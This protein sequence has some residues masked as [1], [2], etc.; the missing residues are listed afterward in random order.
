MKT[1]STVLAFGLILGLVYALPPLAV[2]EAPRGGQQ[3][4]SALV[5]NRVRFL[6]APQGEQ[7][8]VGGV[9]SGSNTSATQGFEVLAEI[10][11]LPPAGQWSELTLP[12]KKPY[13]WIRYEAPRGSYGRVSK[14]EFCAGNT[15]LAGPLI[16]PFMSSKWSPVVTD[17]PSPGVSGVSPDGQYVGIDLGEKASCPRP[18]IRPGGGEFSQA[19]T[20]TMQC[21]MPGAMIRYTTDGTPPTRENG[22]TYSTSISIDKTTTFRAVGFCDGLAPSP[23]ADAVLLLPPIGRRT[24]LHLGN[25]LTG[26]AVGR[27]ALHART[28][29]V[30]HDTKAFLMGGGIARTLWNTAMIGSGDTADQ[31]RWKDLFTTTNSMGGVGTYP[32]A[33]VEQAAADWKKLWPS[34]SHVSDVTFQPRDADVAEEADY[35]I[36][37]L[38]LVRDKFP[39]VQPWLYVEWTEM[40][41]QRAT[42][43]GLVPSSQMKTLYP[44]LTW[45]ESMSAMMLYGEEVQRAMSQAY[46]TGKRPRII[47]VA[48]ALGWIHHQ[49]ET[50]QF[51]GATA[52]D[53]YPLLFGD[54]VHLNAEGSFLVEATWYAAMYGQ[55]P[56]GKLLPLHLQL[57]PKQTL[58]I[59]RVALDVVKNY[60][61]CGLYEEGTQRAGEPQFS[62][63]PSE[64]SGVT[65]VRLASS[66]PGAWFRYTLDGS[67]PT[68]TRGY[69]Y[70]GVVSVPRGATLKAVAYKSGLADSAAQTAKI[71]QSP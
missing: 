16:A 19:V 6:P 12:N 17:K 3:P 53:F 62:V 21:N 51:P 48:L 59:Q 64:A 39:E 13:R 71:T 65:R 10:K 41:R 69:I 7:A 20:V 24:T 70:C 54:K 37:W 63:L 1:C 61:D 60:P 15:K 40:E 43:K 14:I 30:V 55:S 45:E 27:F 66:S 47:P 2:G 50:G 8:M 4:A 25:S 58:A 56:E 35:T 34:L 5:F 22:Q 38:K 44:A 11:N 29:G 49:I 32:V 23:D 31:Q 18:T 36:R 57:T 9:F 46:S 33:K 42:D 28:T 26:N 52:S 68:R 67:Q